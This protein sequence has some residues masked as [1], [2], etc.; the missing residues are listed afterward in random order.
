MIKHDEICLKEDQMNDDAQQLK[1]K[2]VW[3]DV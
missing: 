1:K 3:S 2:N